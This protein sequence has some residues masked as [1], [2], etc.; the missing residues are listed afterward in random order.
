MATIQP[1]TAREPR[2]RLRAKTGRIVEIMPKPGRMAM[3]TSGC[4]KNQNRCCHRRGDPP[5]CG[6]LVLDRVAGTSF[7]NPAGLVVNDQ[8]LPH[9]GGS[10]LLWQHLFWFFGHP[11]V[12][13]AVLSGF[14]IIS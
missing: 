3:Y 5:A 7:F 2:R 9:S 1:M 8:A 12:Y 6:L 4:P 13:I 11:E 10:P 14:G